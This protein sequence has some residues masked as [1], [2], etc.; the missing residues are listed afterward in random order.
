M[1]ADVHPNN[2]NGKRINPATEDNQVDLLNEVMESTSKNS[3]D[4]GTES[5]TLVAGAAAIIASDQPC[6]TVLISATAKVN[7]ENS[8]EN[9]ADAAS[10]YIPKDIV[11]E[12]PVRNTNKLSFYS[13]AGATVHIMWRD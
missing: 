8:I 9:A 3:L 4:F 1:Q 12:I 11:V 5:L 7:V 2:K 13:A 6:R 10:F